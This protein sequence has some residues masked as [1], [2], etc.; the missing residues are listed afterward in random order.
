MITAIEAKMGT[1][2]NE[3]YETFVCYVEQ[4]IRA[5]MARGERSCHFGNSDSTMHEYERMAKE[6]FSKR[7]FSFKPTGYNNGVW[8]LTQ[9][10]CW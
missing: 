9:D 8:Q 10:I 2:K 1:V 4:R 3:K 7:G 6:E 5:A